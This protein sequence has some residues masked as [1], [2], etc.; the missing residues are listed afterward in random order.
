MKKNSWAHLLILSLAFI[1]SLYSSDVTVGPYDKGKFIFE[2]GDSVFDFATRL[3]L[4]E[5]FGAKNVS[6]LNNR[7]HED[8]TLFFRHTFDLSF[9]YG[10]GKKCYD[11]EI[12][13]LQMG[14]RNRG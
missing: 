14:M 3:V 9:H 11:H 7:N 12:I 8:R 2:I 6:F 10:Y 4:P 13:Q 5:G 1:S